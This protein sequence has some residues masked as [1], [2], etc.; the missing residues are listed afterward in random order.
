MST[1]TAET[2]APAEAAKTKQTTKKGGQLLKSVTPA[3]MKTKHREQRGKDIFKV[4]L[5]R[6]IVEEDFNRRS[7]SSY[8]DIDGLADSIGAAGQAESVKGHRN[9]DGTWTLTA[10]HRRY[11]AMHRLVERTGKEQ[12]VDII[13]TDAKDIVTRLIAQYVENV[14]E[15]T[16]D[17][18]KAMI[19]DGLIKAGLKPKDVVAR[20]G[21]AQPVVS[22]LMA[23]LKT[24]ESVQQALKKGKISGGT[25]TKMRSAINANTEL[26]N[27]GEALAKEVEEAVVAAEAEGKTKATDRHSKGLAG[28]RTPQ[29]IMKQTIARFDAKVAEGE[30]LTSAQTFALDL[31]RKLLTKPSDKMLDNFL[32]KYEG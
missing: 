29:T 12:I 18:D 6:I 7:E 22:K 19:V 8:G 2:A 27:K 4:P 14:K 10:G 9:P 32:A 1:K 16:S 28:V 25:V 13:K 3:K 20:L 30:E 21:I 11:L 15:P 23:L 31:F 17:Y 26:K 24:D 5:S